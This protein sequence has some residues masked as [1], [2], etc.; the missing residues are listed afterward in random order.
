[1]AKKR[2]GDI[3]KADAALERRCGKSTEIRHHT[4]TDIDQ[5]RVARGTDLLQFLP[6]GGERFEV[7]MVIAGAYRNEVSG[8]GALCFQLFGDGRSVLIGEPHHPIRSGKCVNNCA[9]RTRCVL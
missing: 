4:T 2:G 8:H 7:L 3:D 6:N 1:M 9:E 5:Q